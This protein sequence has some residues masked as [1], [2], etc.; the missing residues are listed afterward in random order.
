MTRAISVKSLKKYLCYIEDIECGKKRNRRRRHQFGE[1]FEDDGDNNMEIDFLKS[2]AIKLV[3]NNKFIKEQITKLAA[4]PTYQLVVKD[5]S[6]IQK[7]IDKV[8][9]Y[10]DIAKSFAPITARIPITLAKTAINKFISVAN[11]RFPPAQT[12][13]MV[14]DIVK[15]IAA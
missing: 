15:Q 12:V 8:N 9:Q 3:R 14:D 10:V 6:Q 11:K 5:P 2:Q 1:G 7:L 13:K 4:D